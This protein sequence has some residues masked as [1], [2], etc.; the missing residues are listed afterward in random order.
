MQY[1][2]TSKHWKSW[3]TYATEKSNQLENRTKQKFAG[4]RSCVLVKN[5]QICFLFDLPRLPTR[6]HAGACCIASMV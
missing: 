6:I 5:V 4:S 1:K 3:P 2:D